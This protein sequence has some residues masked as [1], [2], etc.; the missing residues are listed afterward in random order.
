MRAN[1]KQNSLKCAVSAI[2]TGVS[3]SEIILLNSAKGNLL[4][5]FSAISQ[6]C[7]KVTTTKTRR[8]Q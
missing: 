1:F 3:I 7:P 5:R 8:F 4:T 2:F 6:I